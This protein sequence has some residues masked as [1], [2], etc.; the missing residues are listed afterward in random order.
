[1]I[2]TAVQIQQ[3]L[4]ILK[5]NYLAFLAEQL[6]LDYLSEGDK[7]ILKAA[8]IDLNKFKNKKGIIEQAYLFGILA[9]ALGDERA[10]TLEYDDFLRFIKSSN[11]IPLT[12]DEEF[13][14]EQLK[15]RAYTDL[16]SLGNR[17]ATGTSNV[18]I[19][20]NQQQQN[21]LQ[22]IVR[23]KAIN[24]VKYRQSAAKL[25]SELGHATDDWQRDWLR[26]SYYLLHEAYN[27]GRA[28]NI[29]KQYGEDAEVYF[30]TMKGACKHCIRLYRTDPEDEDSQPIV[31]KLKDIVANGNNI[32]RSVEDYKPTLAPVHP[33]CRCTV[34]YKDP[35]MD[36]DADTQSFTKVKAIKVTNDKLKDIDWNKVI[37]ITK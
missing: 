31:F 18:I 10:K 27:T 32:G 22:A 24:A 5:R 3:V 2:F 19:R 23:S 4:D 15:L 26:I 1:M 21:D 37:K 35:N 20:A 16:N 34:H 13:A 33:Y 30:E 9:D 7:A 17:I 29:F 11:F 8:G 14:L 25:A 12:A 6:G 28:K 36:W